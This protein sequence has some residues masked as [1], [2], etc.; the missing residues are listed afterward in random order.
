MTK[1]SPN[2][3]QR[4]HFVSQAHAD[5]YKP[6]HARLIRRGD[7]ESSFN[8]MMPSVG[9]PNMRFNVVQKNTGFNRLKRVSPEI[10]LHVNRTQTCYAADNQPYANHENQNT[11]TGNTRLRQT[12]RNGKAAYDEQ[13]TGRSG[14]Y[15][16]RYSRTFSLSHDRDVNNV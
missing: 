13:Q 3:T 8:S 4:L 6:E 14:D 5:F 7:E 12:A 16:P 9:Y 11:K 10:V 15:Y 2:L 1:C